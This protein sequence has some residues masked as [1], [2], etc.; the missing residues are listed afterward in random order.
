MLLASG[1]YDDSVSDANK[2]L[3]L[4]Q[5]DEIIAFMKEKRAERKLGEKVPTGTKGW[6]FSG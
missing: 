1:N 2:S 6:F 5:R 4:T 3:S